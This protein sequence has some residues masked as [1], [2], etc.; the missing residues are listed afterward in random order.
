MTPYLYSIGMWK[1][2]REVGVHTVKD[3]PEW[4]DHGYLRWWNDYYSE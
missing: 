3:W 1:N 2:G 4:V